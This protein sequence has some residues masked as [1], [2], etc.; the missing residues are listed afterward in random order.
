MPLPPSP[1]TPRPDEDPCCNEN[2]R[3]KYNQV[4]KVAKRFGS[5]AEMARALGISEGAISHWRW[6]PP[7]GGDGLIPTRRIRQILEI[8][9]EIGLVIRPED[10]SLEEYEYSY[11]WSPGDAPAEPPKP[12]PTR[13][14][15]KR[16]S[17]RMSK[18][19]A[20]RKKF[21]QKRKPP[22][23]DEKEGEA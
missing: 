3:P 22:I 16:I 13:K 6:S 23:P 20:A 21:G 14:K 10:L 7:Y 12:Y 8:A 4:D 19:H 2:G 5:Q 11:P 18:W 17:K 9:R 15:N 1:R